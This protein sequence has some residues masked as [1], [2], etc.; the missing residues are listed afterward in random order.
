M[1]QKTYYLLISLLALGLS[2]N[3]VDASNAPQDEAMNRVVVMGMIH[4]GHRQSK[5]YGLDRVKN[6]IR[7]INP[8]Y[9][10]TEIPPDRLEEAANQF[11][12]SGT[13]TESRVR[14]FPEYTDALFPLT[15]EL[16]FTIIPCAAWTKEMNDS[17]R[18][19]LSEAQKTHA[20]EYEEMQKA[21]LQASAN[22][23]SLGDANHPAIIHTDQYD[24][25]VK[26]GLEPYDRHFNEMI[27]EGGWENINAAHYAYIDK[28]LN[29]HRGEGKTF[30][31][32]FGSWHKYYIKEQLKK[33]T[34][35][36]VISLTNFLDE[37]QDSDASELLQQFTESWNAEKWENNFRG[38]NYMRT[39][40]DDGWK[41]RM[42]TMQSLIEGGKNSIKALEENLRNENTP[43]RILAA[44]TL[45]YLA[46]HAN[47][48]TLL[49]IVKNDADPAVRLY[50]VDAI[51]M[52]GKDQDVDW[53]E[54]AKSERNRDVLK[55]MNYAKERQHAPVEESVV[56]EMTNW[57]LDLLDT[58]V[59][60]KEA[61]DFTLQSVE[62]ES[63]TLSELRGQPVVLVFIYGDT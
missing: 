55:H 56:E 24:A 7:K 37:A 9:V 51:G 4:G 15:K 45:G 30:L 20:K 49:Q 59:V 11:K 26:E 18:K 32:T 25:Y 50:A 27:G 60:G 63:F 6:L 35:V 42:K 43:T 46:P 28:A 29:Q 58:A 3:A 14:V 13:I 54:L 33:R 8:D 39:T 36:E 23:A 31:I 41:L 34:D 22:I 16:D 17:R 40:G 62:G 38:V 57:D 5:T 2:V 61:P 21:Q 52:S 10:L 47:I 44:Q 12:E 19:T 1:F 53:T 48:E